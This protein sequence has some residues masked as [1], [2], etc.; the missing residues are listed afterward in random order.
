M[1]SGICKHAQPAGEGN[2]QADSHTD[3]HRYDVL[4]QGLKLLELVER[5]LHGTIESKKTRH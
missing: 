1:Y 4:N 5:D 3:T 2:N